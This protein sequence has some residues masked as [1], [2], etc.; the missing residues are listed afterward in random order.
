VPRGR[1]PGAL[2][3]DGVG[4]GELLDQ[5]LGIGQAGG[6]VLGA[7]EAGDVG[8]DPPLAGVLDVAALGEVGEEDLVGVGRELQVAGAEVVVGQLD[9]GALGQV[10]ARSRSCTRMS[11]SSP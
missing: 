3:R 2:G 11:S 7:L 5:H 6:V 10:A 4:L 9:A 8:V 1:R